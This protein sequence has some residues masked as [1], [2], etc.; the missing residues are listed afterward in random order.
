[1][2]ITDKLNT[3]WA[4]NETM[5]ALFEFRAVTENAL[6]N[7]QEAVSRI[8][9]ITSTAKFTT[10]DPELKA[11][12]IAVRKIIFDARAALESHGAFVNWKQV[13]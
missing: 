1:M 8:D 11:E 4:T 6:N 2:A 10:V 12:G 5:D 7:L 13:K 3:A 9:A